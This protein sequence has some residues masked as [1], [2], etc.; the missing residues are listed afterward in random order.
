MRR[1]T[2]N[3]TY[4]VR[5]IASSSEVGLALARTWASAVIRKSG[6]IN[7][8]EGND[9]QQEQLESDAR[10]MPRDAA[11]TKVQ[12]IQKE[13]KV[14]RAMKTATQSYQSKHTREKIRGP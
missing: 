12:G 13:N 9:T 3:R 10:L 11:N 7:K 5:V 8:V 6:A 1:S 4:H 2:C 14:D